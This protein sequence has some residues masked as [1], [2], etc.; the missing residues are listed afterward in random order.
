MTI[1]PALAIAMAIGIIILF[2]GVEIIYLK[3]INKNWDEKN[4]KLDKMFDDFAKREK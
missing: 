1:H 3:F 4:K 2:M